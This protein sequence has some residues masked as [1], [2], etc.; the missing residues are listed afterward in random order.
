ME[1]LIF[2]LILEGIQAV[3]RRL[4]KPLSKAIPEIGRLRADEIALSGSAG[5]H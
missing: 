4:Q 3:D 2:H 5:R 1:H